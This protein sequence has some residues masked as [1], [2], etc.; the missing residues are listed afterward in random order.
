MR[1]STSTEIESVVAVERAGRRARSPTRRFADAQ[2]RQPRRAAPA[3]RSSRPCCAR[4]GLQAE[5][6]ADQVE[7]RPGRPRLGRAGHRVRAR[8]AARSSRSKPQKSSGR[9][10][11]RKNC[12]RLEHRAGD[13]ARLLEQAVAREARR[14]DARC[15]AA[16]SC[17]GG[18]RWGCSRPSRW[19][20]SGCPSRSTC[21]ARV[22]DVAPRC[23][24]LRRRD[25]RTT[26][27][28]R[29]WRRCRRPALVA[30][31]RQR[32]GAGV[33][34]PE[35]SSKRSRSV[36]AASSWRS[37]ELVVAAQPRQPRDA[38]ARRDR[39]SPGPRPARWARRRACRR[40]CGS[41]P[42][43][44]FQPW[45]ARP[46]VGLPL[47]LD[48]AVA[49]EVA[50]LS[51][52]P[53]RGERVRPEP[54][55]ELVVAGPAL[56][57]VEQ[58]QPQR[59]RVDRAV[60]GRVRDLVGA[61]QLAGA[62]LVQDLARLRVA[63]VVDLGRL[64]PRQQGQR[65]ARDLRPDGQQLQAVM[66]E[67]RPNRRA[68]PGHAGGDVALAGLRAGVE[69]QAQVGAARARAPARRA[70]GSCR[71][72]RELWRHARCMPRPV[73]GRRSMRR[74]PAAVQR[75][76]ARLRLRRRGSSSCQTRRSASARRPAA[77]VSSSSSV[78]DAVRV[79]VRRRGTTVMCGDTATCVRR[80]SRP[81]RDRRT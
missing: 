17:P 38:A 50:V 63:P 55:D 67:S 6:R 8:A 56:V 70:G 2:V 7:Q 66:I 41:S 72:P 43:E 15:R 44:S 37:R 74:R 59:R 51:I 4:V 20:A 42:H 12:G 80:R 61:R 19:T 47:V 69:Q 39:R 76:S 79:G 68:E 62:Q 5:R 71:S 18:S 16:R 46:R 52:Q 28:A 40:G 31:E 27:R 30:V 54:V 75:R 73:V 33:L 13:L 64:E 48:E 81:G 77:S 65:V 49:V 58:H 11:S 35:A 53:Q 23:G 10:A 14:A 3:R 57:L 36:S 78:H 9:R 22:S 29:R 25:A 45:L 21:P 34:H 60:V 1:R 24:A 32:V 26:G